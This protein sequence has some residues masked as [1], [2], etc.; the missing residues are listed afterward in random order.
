MPA[1][2]V[3]FQVAHFENHGRLAIQEAHVGP[4]SDA[5]KTGKNLTALTG[6]T[7][8]LGGVD[9]TAHGIEGI[10]GHVLT[11]TNGVLGT[12]NVGHLIDAE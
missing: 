1:E 10:A 3:R 5:L 4:I 2:M 11:D 9:L 8:K 12:L 6:Q 7:Y